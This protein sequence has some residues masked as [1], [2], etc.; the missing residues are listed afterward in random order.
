MLKNS[1]FIAD[2]DRATYDE[3]GMN[4]EELNESDQSMW[5][6]VYLLAHLRTKPED[7]FTG[8]ETMIFNA[9][10]KGDISWMPEKISWQM[11]MKNV[12]ADLED[13]DDIINQVEK[14]LMDHS[15]EQ[16]SVL[17]SLVQSET[18]SIRAE[19][20]SIKQQLQD[21]D[22]QIKSFGGGVRDP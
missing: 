15:K 17:K 11:Q 4:F 1:S 22:S 8:A 19:N 16:F 21:L 18:T 7:D 2:I 12:A 3:L 5:K 20:T 14:N 10:E 6:Y 13:T 9:I